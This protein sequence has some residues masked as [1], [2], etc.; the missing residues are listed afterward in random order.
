MNVRHERLTAALQH[1]TFYNM[2]RRQTLFWLWGFVLALATTAWSFVVRVPAAESSNRQT[3]ILAD[4]TQYEWWLMRWSNNEV[5]CRVYTDHPDLPT[6]NEVEVYCGKT[7][8]AEWQATQP[9]IYAEMGGV[10][11]Q[12]CNGFYFFQVSSEPRQR[13]VLV[14]LPEP[15]IWVTLTNCE[16]IGFENR[17]TRIPSLVFQAQEPLP[18]EYIRAINVSIGNETFSCPA[19]VCEVPLR[20]TGTQGIEVVFWADSSYGDSTP[21]YTAQV[22]VVDTGVGNFPGQSGWYVD[23]I[24]ERWLGGSTLTSCAQIWQTFPSIGEPPL[25]LANPNQPEL[26]VSAEPYVYLAGRLIAVGVVDASACPAGGLLANGWANACGLEAALPA[27]QNW[28]NRFDAQIIAAAEQT[29]IPSQLLKNLFAQESQFWPGAVRD[30]QTQEFGLGRLTE[31]GAD[32]V[33]LWNPDFFQQF[34]PLILNATACSNGYTFFNAEEQALLRGALTLNVSADC[35]ECP[36][37]IDLS[38]IDFSIQLFAETLKANCQQV[39]Q[40]VYNTTAKP[41]AEVMVYED[42]WRFTLANYHAGAGCL[43]EAMLQ[44]T[45]SGNSLTWANV[46]ANLDPTCQT[47]I[48]FV[49]NITREPMDIPVL[50]A[51]ATPEP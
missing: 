47:A 51:D 19:D 29:G 30:A 26:L 36:E 38:Y 35:P 33:L 10:D 5:V 45:Q 7:L 46:A 40:V 9:C 50:E 3:E 17:C 28:Q 1:D 8:L 4:Y 44:T 23:V 14:D 43:T 2:L 24:S 12:S 48:T 42:L 13:T 6:E 32:T 18:N 16:S 49:E 39:G 25:W 21:V 27:V 20:A 41:P 37:G 11:A 15:Q 34:C 22:R 31:L